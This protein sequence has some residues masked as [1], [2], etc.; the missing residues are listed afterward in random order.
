MIIINADP[1]RTLCTAGVGVLLH[2]IAFFIEIFF[3]EVDADM[4]WGHSKSIVS[5]TL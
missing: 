1:T 3:W 4:I 5:E 2:V